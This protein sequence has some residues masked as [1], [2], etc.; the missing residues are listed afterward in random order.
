MIG[1]EHKISPREFALSIVRTLRDAGHVAYFAGGCVRDELLGIEPKDYDVATDATPQRIG[2]LFP[3]TE[4]VGAQF[5]V[6][7]VKGRGQMVEVA[8]FR[9]DGT[10]SDRRRPDTI[11]FSDPRTDAA[12]RDFTVNALFL[13]PLSST[14]GTVIDFVNGLADINAKIL[15]A[16]GDPDAR[17][18]EDDLRILRAIRFAAR[19]KFSID[20]STSEAIRRHARG[21]SGISRERVGEEI[22]KMLLNANRAGAARLLAQH[23]LVGPCLGNLALPDKSLT[24]ED[25]PV[26]ANIASTSLGTILA[27]W[28]TDLELSVLPR[29]MLNPRPRPDRS[30]QSAAA[31]CLR[32]SL[33]LSNQELQEFLGAIEGAAALAAQWEQLSLAHQKRFAQ[34]QW[35]ANGLALLAA[36]QPPA[37]AAIAERLTELE[38]SP[39]GISP[40]PLISGD[41]L[42]EIGQVPGPKFKVILEKVYDAQLSGLIATR[43]QGLEL[44]RQLCV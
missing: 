20:P 33:C 42:A 25:F 31:A 9:A 10:Y 2:T 35:F 34:N 19:F 5:G 16:V 3:R 18:Q 8:T 36:S 38:A 6:M 29:D 44:V 14:Q 4:E 24:H 37:A 39:G 11:T 15:R 30:P 32:E 1:D 43:E 40:V 28:L 22:R 41:D 27:A 21:L 23:G 17:F 13:D 26:L 7:I 12:R